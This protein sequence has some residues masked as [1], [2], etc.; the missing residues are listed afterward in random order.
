LTPLTK[1]VIELTEL[2]VFAV[3][4]VSNISLITFDTSR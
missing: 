1:D 2:H 4:K 3:S